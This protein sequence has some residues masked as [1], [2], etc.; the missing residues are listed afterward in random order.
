MTS[1]APSVLPLWNSIPSR[2]RIV[3]TVAFLSAVD[4]LGQPV[5]LELELRVEDHQRLPAGHEARLVGLRDDVLA[6]DDVLGR[7][8][9]DPDA[10]GAAPLALPACVSAAAL[11]RRASPEL[12][13][14]GSDT[15]V[16]P[17]AVVSAAALLSGAAALVGS[18]AAD[19]ADDEPPSSSLP[20]HAAR[21][22]AAAMA[23]PRTGPR[24]G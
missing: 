23:A 22:S 13:G 3:H 12:D 8:A 15:L 9:G 2:T 18:A 21:P 1:S 20:P 17:A 19:V 6:V 14:A 5:E 10:E 4:L 24:A 11:G 7:A 16:V